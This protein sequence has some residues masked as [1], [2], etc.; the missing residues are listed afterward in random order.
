MDDGGNDS[1][2]QGGL[3]DGVYPCTNDGLA[4]MG[5]WIRIR[6]HTQD[7]RK[8]EKLKSRMGVMLP[9]PDGS[10]WEN[11]Q[12]LIRNRNLINGVNKRSGSKIY[13][14]LASYLNDLIE[15]GDHRV[16]KT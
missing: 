10:L 2:G 15:G 16:F 14:V 3:Q 4:T 6:I 5:A 13:I 8:P 7:N 11:T 1:T 9:H 12:L